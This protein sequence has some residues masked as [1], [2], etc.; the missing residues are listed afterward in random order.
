[1][2]TE[3]L[4]GLDL[5][6]LCDGKMLEG[7][8]GAWCFELQSNRAVLGGSD[9]NA[10]KRC[11]SGVCRQ[12]III[13]QLLWSKTIEISVDM[14]EATQISAVYHE[15]QALRSTVASLK[16]ES[17][18]SQGLT[19]SPSFLGCSSMDQYSGVIL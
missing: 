14:M 12:H 15:Q 6:R 17:H 2:C 5:V 10:K 1:M 8:G 4:P 9:R 18:Q 3:K 13:N 19:G 11:R 16:A 7:E